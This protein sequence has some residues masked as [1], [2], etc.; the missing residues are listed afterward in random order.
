MDVC[1][2]IAIVML[3]TSRPF[4]KLMYFLKLCYICLC[5]ITLITI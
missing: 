1:E 4:N 2:V 5:M 3:K